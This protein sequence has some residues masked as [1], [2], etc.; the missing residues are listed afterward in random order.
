MALLKDFHYHT[1]E[2]LHE[3]LGILMKS[4]EPLLLA[5]GTFVLNYLKKS[6]KY[7]AD[8]IGLKKIPSLRGISDSGD[9]VSIGAMTTIA[10]LAESDLIRKHFPSFFQA[11]RHLGTTPIRNM[12]TIGGNVASRFFWVDLPAVLISLGARVCPKSYAKPRSG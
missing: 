3:A 2:T 1:P 12:A 4:K 10:E 11:L 9:S 5:G 6:P 8:V 7:P